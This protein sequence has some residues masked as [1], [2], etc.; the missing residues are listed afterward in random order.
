MPLHTLDREELDFALAYL[1]GAL[2]CKAK[3]VAI[4]TT[5]GELVGQYLAHHDA[6]QIEALLD[7]AQSLSCGFAR[8]MGAGQFHYNLNVGSDG[9]TLTLLLGDSYLVCINVRE[10]KSLDAF[11]NGVREG[12]PPLRDL[13]GIR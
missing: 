1:L 11:V 12:L 8:A 2:P 9:A 5:Q 4:V 13:L 10:P 6:A 7:A 3:G